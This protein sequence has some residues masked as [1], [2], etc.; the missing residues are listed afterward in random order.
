MISCPRIRAIRAD[1]QAENHTCV[2]VCV[3]V[4]VGVCVCVYVSVYVCARVYVC[5]C[6][7]VCVHKSKSKCVCR[8]G[9]SLPIGAMLDMVVLIGHFLDW[10]FCLALPPFGKGDLVACIR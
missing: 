5:V 9:E 6:V 2:C 10:P 1:T 3:C 4:Y 8:E 7:R